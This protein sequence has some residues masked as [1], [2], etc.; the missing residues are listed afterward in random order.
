MRVF[1]RHASTPPA[2]VRQCLHPN[3]SPGP[4]IHA[5]IVLIRHSGLEAPMRHRRPYPFNTPNGRPA[6]RSNPG[7]GGGDTSLLPQT[8]TPQ[9]AFHGRDRQGDAQGASSSLRR[10]GEGY[11]G[12]YL[13]YTH[14]RRLPMFPHTPHHPTVPLPLPP[15]H[16]PPSLSSRRRPPPAHLASPTPSPSPPA[17]PKRTDSSVP[18]RG[19]E[20]GPGGRVVRPEKKKEKKGDHTLPAFPYLQSS[21]KV[22][23]DRPL[24]HFPTP[25]PTPFR[26]TRFCPFEPDTSI[27]SLG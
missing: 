20:V 11:P 6:R 14:K 9:S 22:T 12:T 3:P 23:W 7:K 18:I 4:G 25:L 27:H 15:R 19:P 26:C 17:R 2:T 10:R 1:L 13:T 21:L 24:S 5:P 16:T 8:W